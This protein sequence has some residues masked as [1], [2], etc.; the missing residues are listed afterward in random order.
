MGVGDTLSADDGATGLLRLNELIDFYNSYGLTKP[1]TAQATYSVSTNTQNYTIGSGATWNQT[2]PV[3]ITGARVV[4]TSGGN[5]YRLPM[6]VIDIDQWDLIQLRGLTQPFPR[7]LYYE[8]THP[9]G[10]VKLWPIPDGTQTISIEIDYQTP[11]SSYATLTTAYSFPP[12]Y[13]RAIRLNLAEVLAPE[14][15]KVIDPDVLR[16]GMDSFANLKRQ[17]MV[18]TDLGTTEAAMQFYGHRGYYN[19]YSDT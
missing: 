9:T 19:I 3:A 12:G 8:R 14:Y 6:A 15:G 11:L 4:W 7:A 13:A 16:L 5:T 10:T 17:N 2:W 1:V 18:L